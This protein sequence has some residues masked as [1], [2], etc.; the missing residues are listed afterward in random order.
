MTDAE[1]SR[2]VAGDPDTFVADA[3]MWA[4]AEVVWPRP[5]KLVSLRIDP[6]VLEWYRSQG[7]GYQSRMN[8]VLRAYKE[9]VERE[10]MS[11]RPARRVAK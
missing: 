7:R 11:G 3:S 1:I 10:R 8:A 6:D 4:S 2:S 9:H 5:K